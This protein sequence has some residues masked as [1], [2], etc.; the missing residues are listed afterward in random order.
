MVFCNHDPIKAR[1]PLAIH[2]S[3]NNRRRFFLSPLA[4]CSLQIHKINNSARTFLHCSASVSQRISLGV[5]LPQSYPRASTYPSVCVYVLCIIG[6]VI[7]SINS[8]SDRE[9]IA[10]NNNNI[11]RDNALHSVYYLHTN[12]AR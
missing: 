8:R 11:Y 3:N 7:Y 2:I 10:N 12:C 1:Q 6:I 5:S 9:E 4:V